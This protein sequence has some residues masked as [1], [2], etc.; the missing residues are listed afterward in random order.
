[1]PVLRDPNAPQSREPRR[2]VGRT[3]A[4]VHHLRASPPCATD[5]A[6]LVGGSRSMDERAAA[7]F[8]DV[9]ADD[10]IKRALGLKTQL[11]RAARL[12]ALRPA[13]DDARD[14]RILSAANARGH[15]LAGDAAQPRNLLGDGAG[16]A[17]HGEI[18]A[19]TKRVARQARR[20]DEETNRRAR[21]CMG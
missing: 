15:T 21:A 8:V 13:R 2:I 4:T 6:P 18:D 10:F 16:H 17:R 19:P 1:M 9:D 11:T 7:V 3:A 20:M 12:D 5:E 14:Q